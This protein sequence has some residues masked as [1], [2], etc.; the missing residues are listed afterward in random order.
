MLY[1]LNELCVA[2]Q[3]SESS[4]SVKCGWHRTTLNKKAHGKRALSSEDAETIGRATRS[5]PKLI[6]GA[7]MFEIKKRKIG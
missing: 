2:I 7:I 3:E 1:R 4:I 6:D 5:K